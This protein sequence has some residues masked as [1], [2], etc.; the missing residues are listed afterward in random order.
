MANA[1]NLYKEIMDQCLSCHTRIDPEI[2]QKYADLNFASGLY[3]TE[4]L[5]LYLALAQE[6]PQNAADYYQ[7]ISQIYAAQGNQQEARR[8]RLIAAKAKE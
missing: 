6:V 5:E 1:R 7:K 8:F 3:S 2:K 4:I